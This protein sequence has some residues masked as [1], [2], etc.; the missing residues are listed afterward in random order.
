M[1][2]ATIRETTAELPSLPA[3]M[4]LAPVQSLDARRGSVSRFELADAR[5][6][7]LELKNLHLVDGR[8]RALRAE[9]ATAAGLSARSVEFTRCELGDLRWSGGK[10]SRVR[11]DGCK[12]LAARFENMTLDHVVF[13]ECRLD[14]A[15]LSQVRAIGPVLF[16][17]CSL[18]D[19]EF[20]GCDLSR[21][22]FDDCDLGLTDFGPGSYRG[23]DLRGNDLSSVRGV[24]HLRRVVV[25]RAQ[26]LQ[27]AEALAADLD[28]S[29]GDEI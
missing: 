19:A 23:C 29:F 14:F 28:V 7:A 15:V 24:Q 6:R 1:E 18:R 13:T 27:L 26:L 8:I 25:D 11:F 5:M 10:L 21:S 22:L 16:V 2:R 20:S 12:L 17:R 9:T 3:D 4:E